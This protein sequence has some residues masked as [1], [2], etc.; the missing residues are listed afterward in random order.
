MDRCMDA[1][2][3]VPIKNA[4][5]DT[6]DTRPSCGRLQM[7]LIVAFSLA[8]V[9]TACS[10]T[11][12]YINPAYEPARSF[13][14]GDA[15]RQR[16]LLIG[17]AGAPRPEGE[18]V[19][20]TLSRWASVTPTRTMVIFLGDN[21]YEHGVPA[22]ELG[23][24]SALARLD[25]QLDV[26]RTSGA[27]GLFIPGNHDWK[28]GLE[29]LVRQRDYVRSRAKRTSLL[30]RP[31]SPGPVT[32][33]DL[34]GVRVVVLDTEMWLRASAAEKTQ[35]AS[36]LQRA[37]ATAGSRHVIVA[38]HHPIATH[39]PHGGFRDWRDHLFPLGRV[40]PLKSTPLALLPLPIVGSIYPLVLEPHVIRAKQSMDSP[41]YQEM[42][43][44]LARGLT[45]RPPLVYAAGHDHNLQ[46]L[47][48][49]KAAT[50]GERRAADYLLISGLGSSRKATSVTHKADTIFSHLN[51]GFM[52]LDFYE[53][54]A[55][56]LRIV[57]PPGDEAVY[58][59]WLRRARRSEVWIEPQAA[60]SASQHFAD[61]PR[62]RSPSRARVPSP[63]TQSHRAP[64]L[65]GK[66]CR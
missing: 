56:L 25:A 36:Q 26:L 13:P 53:N 48:G 38:G 32:I 1:P 44:A 5:T 47:D 29:G 4:S 43:R 19:L 63:G 33:D 18:P 28:S 41:A 2:T 21:V 60:L 52:A 20:Q 64:K 51:P 6:A 22:D 17:D 45:P 35:L 8:A 46:V 42:V 37:V 30:P 50:P 9:L 55:V 31:G 14:S 66:S 59:L 11:R 61:R 15:I 49:A 40:R 23:R 24:R 65:A 39:G 10:D 12:P 57:E 62:L 58:S 16:I 54:D 34:A 3:H 27:R 7:R